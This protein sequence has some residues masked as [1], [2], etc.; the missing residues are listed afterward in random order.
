MSNNNNENNWKTIQCLNGTGKKT[1]NYFFEVG[2]HQ[3]P[4]VTCTTFR[5]V[6]KIQC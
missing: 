2:L 6:D 4:V 5:V 3:Y 1:R